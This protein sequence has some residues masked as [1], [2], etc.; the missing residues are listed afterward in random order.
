MNFDALTS[1]GFCTNP[2]LFCNNPALFCNNHRLFSE[3]SER[4]KKYSGSNE[5]YFGSNEND[6]RGMIVLAARDGLNFSAKFSFK[7]G[8]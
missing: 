5:K 6:V 2:A 3:Y 8:H 1:L 4:N 7:I